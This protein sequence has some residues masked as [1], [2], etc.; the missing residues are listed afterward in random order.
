MSHFPDQ[1]DYSDKYFDDVYEY[2]YVTLTE[3]VFKKMPKG[4]LLEELEWRNIGVQ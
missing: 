4:R 3:E 1:I 2:R